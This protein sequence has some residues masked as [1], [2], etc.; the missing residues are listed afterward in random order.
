[1]ILKKSSFLFL[2]L[3]GSWLPI[4]ST[5]LSLLPGKIEAIEMYWV[6]VLS[7]CKANGRT[8]TGSKFRK[9]SASTPVKVVLKTSVDKMCRRKNLLFFFFFTA[10]SPPPPS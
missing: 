1:M 4:R 10:P 7:V 2:P 6:H 9:R 5:I 3:L 8:E